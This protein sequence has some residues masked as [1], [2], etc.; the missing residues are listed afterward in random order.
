M[1]SCGQRDGKHCPPHLGTHARRMP[2]DRSGTPR[3]RVPRCKPTRRVEGWGAVNDS[4]MSRA[5]RACPADRDLVLESNAALRAT[6]GDLPE[7]DVIELGYTAAEAERQGLDNALTVVADSVAIARR[8]AL[9]PR[10]V[11]TLN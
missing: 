7:L 1:V 5:E 2:V 11:V 10:H 8:L 6:H 3:P 9:T 4:E